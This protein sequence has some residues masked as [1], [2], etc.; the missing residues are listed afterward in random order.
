[1]DQDQFECFA[2]PTHVFL[3]E[4]EVTVAATPP[5]TTRRNPVLRGMAFLGIEAL[6]SPLFDAEPPALAR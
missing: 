2:I 3:A 6:P 1:M 4:D 5:A